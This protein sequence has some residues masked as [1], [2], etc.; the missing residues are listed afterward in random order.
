MRTMVKKLLARLPSFS[1]W[2]YENFSTETFL[3]T[4]NYVPLAWPRRAG[5]GI[6]FHWLQHNP[7]DCVGFGVY[8]ARILFWHKR[9]PLFRRCRAEDAAGWAVFGL[10]RN[11]GN[12]CCRSTART[13]WR[14]RQRISSRITGT[15]DASARSGGGAAEGMT[16]DAVRRRFMRK[17]NPP[18]LA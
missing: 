14:S 2:L 11:G 15:G 12:A 8:P 13:A 7:N 5:E 4:W 10:K 16:V 3:V 17:L 18:Y 1:V 6:D 9:W